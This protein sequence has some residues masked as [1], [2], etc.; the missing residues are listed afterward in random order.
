ML[1]LKSGQDRLSSEYK[2]VEIKTNHLQ[3]EFRSSSISTTIGQNIAVK[4]KQT[5]KSTV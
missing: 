1:S 3:F 5:I 4:I 2:A